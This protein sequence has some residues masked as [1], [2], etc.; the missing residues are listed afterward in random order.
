MS[1]LSFVLVTLIAAIPGAWVS[2]QLV[3]ALLSHSGDMATMPKVMVGLTLLLSGLSTLLPAG[4]GLFLRMPKAGGQRSGSGSEPD[5]VSDEPADS[6]VEVLAG[7]SSE[8]IS[9][10]FLD[11]SP[12]DDGEWNTSEFD[13]ETT[14]FSAVVP[15]DTDQLADIEEIVGLDDEDEPQPKKK[16]RK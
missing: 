12:T 14:D 13:S 7:E 6:E 4:V 16:K 10:E 2:Y 1:K 5:S 8:A 15:E 9:G 3:M 11:E